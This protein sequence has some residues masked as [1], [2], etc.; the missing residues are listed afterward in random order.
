VSIS[1]LLGEWSGRST[2]F[3]PDAADERRLVEHP[4]PSTM[5]AEEVAQGA[6]VRCAYT[7]VYEGKPQAGELLVCGGGKAGGNAITAAWIDSWHQRGAVMACVG[8]ASQ[9]A[10][11]VQGS[12]A[13]PPDPDW[14]WRIALERDG[15]AFWLRMTNIAPTGE[16]TPAVEAKY[17]R[18]G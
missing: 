16:E 7:W 5:R 17:A 11:L 9:S 8:T 3:L 14:G 4:S 2:L 15:D 18:M 1:W 12:Y 6:G 10:L 13:A